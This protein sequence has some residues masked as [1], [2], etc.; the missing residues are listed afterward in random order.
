M[1][2]IA[3]VNVNVNPPPVITT[4]NIKITPVV[5]RAGLDLVKITVSGVVDTNNPIN[6]RFIVY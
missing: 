2:S 3:V 4:N 6:Y 5:I 1:P